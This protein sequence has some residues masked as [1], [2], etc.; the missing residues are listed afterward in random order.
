MTQNSKLKGLD[1]QMQIYKIGCRRQKSNEA[2]T[3]GQGKS[4]INKKRTKKNR[5]WF[6]R[7]IQV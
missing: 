3:E 7:Q 6:I 4:D 2:K 1:L 5:Q